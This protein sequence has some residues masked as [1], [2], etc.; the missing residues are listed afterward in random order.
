MYSNADLSP[1]SISH[2][3]DD[4]EN[5][6][7][8]TRTNK[9]ELLDPIRITKRLQT[10]S[11]RRPRINHI[12]PYELMLVVS[13]GLRSGI[14]TYEIDEYAGNAAASLSLSNPYY[15]KLAS[16]IVV[17][18]H[19]KNTKRSLI[20]KMRDAYLRK[21]ISGNISPL[22][23]SEFYKYLESHQDLIEPMIDYNRDFLVDYFGFR[24]FQKLYSIKING[25]VIER[26]QDMYMRTA[27]AIHMH[28]YDM[29]DDGLKKELNAI[30]ETYD[31]LSLKYY[32][33]ASPTYFNAGSTHPQ[34]SSCFLL[35]T[36]D[37]CEGIM[38]TAADTSIIS[39]WG[40]GIG[41]HCNEWR[42]SGA[43]IRGTNGKSSGIVPFLRIYNN[44][45]RAFNQGGKRM[46]SAAIY[47]MPHHPDIINFLKLILPGGEDIQRA[48]DLFYAVWLPNIFMERVK[49]NGIW[50]LFDPDESVDLSNYY[51][52]PDNKRY[53]NKYLEL[54]EKKLYINQIKARDVWEAIFIANEQKG[55]PY[56]CFSDHVNQMSNQKNI[57]IIKSSNL[58]SEIVEFSNSQ[59]TA[60]CNLC[61]ISLS[62]CVKDRYSE[63]E[64]NL[65]EV[66][67][68]LNDEFPLN[69]WFDFYHL[70]TMTKLAARNLDNIIDKNFYPT[71]ETKRS[72][73]RH[74][75][76]GIGFQGM[77]DAFFKM[78]YPFES[79]KAIEL[80]KKIIETM[81][82]SALSQSTKTCRNMYQKIYSNCKNGSEVSILSYFSDNY[83]VGEISYTD[84]VLIPKTVY[85]YP[86][87]L[88]N[89]GSPISKGIFHWELYGLKA[90]DLSGMWDWESLRSHIQT[91]GVRN[92][93]LIALMPTASTSQLL[94][95]NECFEP[96][97]SNI[98]KR[99]TLA[100][101]FIVINKYLINDM[102]RLKLWNNNIK[103]YLMALEGSIQAIDG[104]PNELK[105][106]YKTA[107]EIDQSVLIQQSIDR[108]PFIDQSQS[109]NL[110]VED[111]SLDKFNKMMF[112]AWRGKLKT[113][114]YYLHSRPA[115][116]PQKFTIDPTK[117]KG[118]TKQ[119]EIE[120][121]TRSEA[122]L[123]PLKEVC[124]LCSG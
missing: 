53:T 54:E 95:N 3:H 63:K 2:I 69:P 104:I 99:K 83:D 81:Y 116:M 74:R 45:M 40:G 85:A 6:Y 51:D 118:M 25:V 123:E 60:V 119:L 73:F 65:T 111:L 87:M 64:L 14:T 122:F 68:D 43:M 26:P 57:G 84:P 52:E 79:D 117:Q 29:S 86:S 91:Y 70:S 33:Q 28:T 36:D 49:S 61:S 75:P 90:K 18:N 108:Q 71:K 24:T 55:L 110:Y 92:S 19:Q 4:E 124:D 23:S 106:L 16:R 97:T 13:Q 20:D 105:V 47:I 59:E 32:T 115:V 96:F 17:D 34:Y 31:S 21:D 89:G 12:N 58:C 78:K 27:I 62:A 109:L 11:R 56:I 77:A 94:G 107:W 114:K 7:V 88:W 121:L 102:F 37:S 1:N 82:Y 48:R 15:M 38:K 66:N 100:G 46:G 120:K 72:N 42:S 5:I 50:S 22:V 8:I 101:E 30:Q 80:N 10:L 112:Q 93:L 98:Y 113:G 67:R 103:E 35:G 9:L 76:I 41:I 39:K 44:V